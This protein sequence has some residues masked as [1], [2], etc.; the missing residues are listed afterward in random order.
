ML[1][2]LKGKRVELGVSQKQLAGKLN[3]TATYL[4]MIENNKINAPK[5]EARIKESLL[6]IE[7]EKREVLDI[8]TLS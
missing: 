5:M 6:E 2:T 8:P 7:R 3:I 1:K 4:H